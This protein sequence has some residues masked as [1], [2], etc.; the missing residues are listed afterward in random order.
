MGMKMGRVC[1]PRRRWSFSLVRIR[2]PVKERKEKSDR[3]LELRR[4]GFVPRIGS[5][6]KFQIPMNKEPFGCRV[7]DAPADTLLVGDP[8]TS[9]GATDNCCGLLQ[10]RVNRRH[11]IY[12]LFPFPSVIDPLLLPNNE[13]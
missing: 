11:D 9:F 3:S 13:V 10:E 5:L 8:I 1:F 12:K 4:F 6:E 7:G 2:Q